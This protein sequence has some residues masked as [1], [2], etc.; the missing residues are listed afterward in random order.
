VYTVGDTLVAIVKD[1]AP[2]GSEPL[3]IVVDAHDRIRLR[4]VLEA[5]NLP[6]AAVDAA[7]RRG[8]VSTDP[9]RPGEPP[10][11]FFLLEFR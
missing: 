7:H 6:V 5:W 11:E 10:Q 1:Q 9:N 4:R 8:V 2:P 3:L